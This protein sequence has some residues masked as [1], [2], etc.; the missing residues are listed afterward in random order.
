MEEKIRNQS[1]IA[2]SIRTRKENL[3]FYELESGVG[4]SFYSHNRRHSQSDVVTD[5]NQDAKILVGG[6]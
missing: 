5:S 1:D 2:S 3:A 6:N 4:G